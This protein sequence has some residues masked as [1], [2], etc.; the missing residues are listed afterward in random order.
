MT[1]SGITQENVDLTWCRKERTLLL[2]LP[3][4]ISIPLLQ[5]KEAAAG[6]QTRESRRIGLPLVSKAFCRW[7]C[8][9]SV[10]VSGYLPVTLTN[11]ESPSRDG[12][13][14]KVA[15]V[16]EAHASFL[17]LVAAVAVGASA[18][19]RARALTGSPAQ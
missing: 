15:R 3:V 9:V 12:S 2:H 8:R 17:S 4:Y 1:V 6:P 14:E 7:L 16:P 19:A 11:C 10:R 5:T 18:P 13:G